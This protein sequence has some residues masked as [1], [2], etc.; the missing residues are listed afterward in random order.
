[1]HSIQIGARNAKV[2]AA[3]GADCDHNGV[4]SVPSQ[5]RDHKIAP[6]SMIQLERD[7]ACLKNFAHLRFDYVTRQAVFRNSEI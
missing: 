4:E 1:M 2:A 5:I 6:G 7:I 3:M